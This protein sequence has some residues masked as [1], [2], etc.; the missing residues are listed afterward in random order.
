MGERKG[1]YPLMVTAAIAVIVFSVLGIGAIMGWLPVSRSAPENA[2]ENTT[3]KPIGAA[4][5]AAAECR[6]CGKI[7]SIQVVSVQ[8]KPSGI[9]VVTGGV[10][11][12]ILGHQVGGGV[13]KDLATIGGAA[14]GAYLGNE[15]EKST[16]K[17]TSFRIV[18]R[19]DDGTHRTLHSSTQNFTVGQEVKIINDKIVPVS[20]S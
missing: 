18:V 20:S 13:G 4:Q 3:S 2:V 16:K 10:V 8:G 15:M 19:M 9:G 11:G 14:G 5:N 12:G 7:E 1:F 17:H 6:D